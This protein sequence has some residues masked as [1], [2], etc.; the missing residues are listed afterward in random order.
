MRCYRRILS[1]L[2][3][4]VLVCA[5]GAST[6]A[7]RT[8][9]LDAALAGGAVVAVGE[10]GAILR[11]SDSGHVWQAMAS[12]TEATLTGISFSPAARHGWAVGHDALIL[13]TDDGGLTWR[14]SWQG[15][16]LQLSFLDVCA[17][18]DRHVL[19]VGAYG[20]CLETTDGGKNWIHRKILEDDMHLNRINRGPGASLYLAG[21]HGTLLRST[22]DG[23]TWAP[24]ATPYQGSFYGILPLDSHTLL[25][26]GLR[27]H[28]YRSEDN[29]DTWTLVNVP[30]PTLI[31]TALRLADGTLVF[32]GQSRGLYLSRD[33]GRT[34]SVWSARMT[35]AVAELVQLPDGTILALG[36]AGATILP[37]P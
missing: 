10:G 37:Q 8:L 27:G 26:H 11:S 19:A 20:L 4:P 34:V 21:E 31:A 35:A 16:N 29:G 7:S 1:A 6:V 3:V 33:G 14:K 13:T 30:Q 22:D 15:D 32:A 2:A 18:D 5:A 25:A 17:L 28:L 24:I 9:L 36:E 12:P 23:K